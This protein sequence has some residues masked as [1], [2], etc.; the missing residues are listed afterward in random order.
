M[1]AL[2]SFFFLL[3]ATLTQGRPL[4]RLTCSLRPDHSFDL[5]S[6][7]VEIEESTFPATLEHRFAALDQIAQH[8][9]LRPDCS[10]PASRQTAASGQ[11]AAA[12]GQ[13]ESSDS[14]AD[15]GPTG[16]KASTAGGIV[17]PI[18]WI[19]DKIPQCFLCHVKAKASTPL[20]S[21]NDLDK[22]G[23][24]V[25]WNSYRKVKDAEKVVIGKTPKG[26]KCL[27]CQNCF[28]AIAYDVKYGTGPS[29]RGMGNYK[30]LM[31]KKEGVDIHNNFLASQKKWIEQ[32]NNEPQGHRMS[33]KSKEELLSVHR[34]LEIEKT[35]SSGFHAPKLSFVCEDAWDEKL[36][37]KFDP[38]KVVE[39]EVFGKVKRGIW[40]TV[41]RH[42]VFDY[43]QYDGT[44]LKDVAIEENGAGD[45]VDQAI[46][47]KSGAI[48]AG[49]DANSSERTAK[50]V[51]APAMAM[52][53]QSLLG[54]LHA[55]NAPVSTETATAAADDEHAVESSSS[56]GDS[57]SEGDDGVV[58]TS[59]LGAYFGGPAASGQ[60][61]VVAKQTK[62]TRKTTPVKDSSKKGFGKSP[63]ELASSSAH[64]KLKNER[65]FSTKLSADAS[66]FH[67]GDDTPMEPRPL[68]STP[69]E[70]RPLAS[71]A[72][73]SAA[74]VSATVAA[75]LRLDGRGVRMQENI[76]E[77]V[78]TSQGQLSSLSF[79][80]GQESA[81]LTGDSLAAFQKD[82]S[83]KSKMLTTM[84]AS[85]KVFETRIEKSPNKESFQ[86]YAI[87]LDGI[88]RK[89]SNLIRF[90]DFI[91]GPTQ[92][93]D[94]GLEAFEAKH[95]NLCV[96]FL[97]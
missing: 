76:R 42:G 29:N 46:A 26:K 58:T 4:A 97:V 19:S 72:A 92:D 11:N 51:E 40:K 37:G 90:A 14:G 17:L 68:A 66:A 83:N 25:P 20:N 59:R 56:G 89:T 15:S 34:R 54:L 47:A 65:V 62:V 28:T 7:T 48:L 71:T 84:R 33:L 9:G 57:E 8:S 44:A 41:G 96:V 61:T 49:F 80:F 6:E 77:F 3:A 2:H 95:C 10:P 32:H 43:D 22:Y 63:S 82:L 75:T 1:F 74:V 12:S 16:S 86:E 85:A 36:D 50:A 79:L 24:L 45:F 52:D 73:A 88:Q 23:G 87:D 70:E 91:K 53:L 21:G 93:L 81:A 5:M 35:R 27:I 13:D 64:V 69:T 78:F 67:F 39:A 38:S 30:K 60:K 31:A 18:I 94:T 55:Q